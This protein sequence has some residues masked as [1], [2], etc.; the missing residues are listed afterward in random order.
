MKESGKDIND[1]LMK[2]AGFRRSAEDDPSFNTCG[3]ITYWINDEGIQFITSKKERL[4]LKN[5]VKYVANNVAYQTRK[6]SWEKITNAFDRS[7]DP[8]IRW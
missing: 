3:D 7:G 6:R 2:E 5:L 8:F 1:K 4:T